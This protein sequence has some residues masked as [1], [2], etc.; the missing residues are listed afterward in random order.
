MVL[1][2]GREKKRNG[3]RND[4][5]VLFVA[6][7]L[8]QVCLQP[9][10]T[11]VI[12]QSCVVAPWAFSLIKYL[13]AKLVLHTFISALT[14]TAL[15]S[16]FLGDFLSVVRNLTAILS[17]QSFPHDRLSLPHAKWHKDCLIVL[18]NRF[19]HWGQSEKAG[20]KFH[21][22][23]SVIWQIYRA[24]DVLIWRLQFRCLLLRENSDK[25]G[26]Y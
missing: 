13:K 20:T 8:S 17:Q 11:Q 25:V 15:P 18:S 1:L 26:Y 3:E 9:R 12:C 6:L 24:G 14:P 19:T 16:L 21:F 10:R 5:A 22:I 23:S 4:S 7:L 2:G